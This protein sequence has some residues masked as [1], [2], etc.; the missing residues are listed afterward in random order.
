MLLDFEVWVLEGLRPLENLEP[1][2]ESYFLLARP[3]LSRGL[4]GCEGT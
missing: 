4:G 3:V 2:R 1:L